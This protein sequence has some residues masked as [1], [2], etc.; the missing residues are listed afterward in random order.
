MC[1]LLTNTGELLKGTEPD[2][3]VSEPQYLRSGDSYVS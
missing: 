1:C 2:Y 3:F